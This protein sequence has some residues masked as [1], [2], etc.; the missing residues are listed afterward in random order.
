[1]ASQSQSPKQDSRFFS[2]KHSQSFVTLKVRKTHLQKLRTVG[3]LRLQVCRNGG[4]VPTGTNNPDTSTAS[5]RRMSGEFEQREPLG[6]QD[7]AMK[8]AILGYVTP[9]PVSPDR[10]NG[11]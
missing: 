8:S 11:Q 10:L 6:R 4:R 2:L 3:F 7:R 9:P 5:S 1:M